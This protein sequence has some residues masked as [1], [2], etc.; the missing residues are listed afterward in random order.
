[1]KGFLLDTLLY[2]QR[3]FY[4]YH[5]ELHCSI[6]VLVIGFAASSSPGSQAFCLTPC[7]VLEE[8]ASWLSQA[9]MLLMTV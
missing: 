6:L 5:N 2:V 7:L 9:I 8:T 4:L 1:M 3:C